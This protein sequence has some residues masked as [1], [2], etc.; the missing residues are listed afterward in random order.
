MT[1]V[2][3]H[4]WEPVEDWLAARH[5]DLCDGLS[6]FLDPDAGLRETT[7]LHA[8]HTG[9]LGTLDSSLDTQA[10]LDAILQPPAAT[11]PPTPPGA[12][13]TAAVIAAAD[14]AIRM[15]LRRDPVILA[16]I[17]SDLIVRALAITNKAR[18]ARDLNRDIDHARDVDLARDIARARDLNRAITRVLNNNGNLVCAHDITRDL[19][20]AFDRARDIARGHVRAFDYAGHDLTL[21]HDIARA[22]DWAFRGGAHLH[23]IDLI[24]HVYRGVDLLLHI[25]RGRAH[26]HDLARAY[27]IARDVA[28]QTALVVGRTLGVQQVEGLAAALLEG[29]LDDFTHADLAHADLTGRD[30]TG[31][32]WS[33]WGTWWPPGTD[34]DQLRARSREVAHGTGVYVIASPGDTDKALHHARS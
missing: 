3:A 4:G 34:V 15:A 20:N 10:G 22:L 30:L 5:R 13:E 32:R 14:P 28:H 33:Y 29:A 24:N 8:E 21:T 18:T 6:R 25:T 11:A 7:M 23:D 17:L 26:A 12:P 31:V 1:G 2:P 19:S 27:D 16:V 9:L